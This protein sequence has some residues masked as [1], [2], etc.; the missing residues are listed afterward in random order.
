MT[1]WMPKRTLCSRLSWRVSR[2]GLDAKRDRISAPVLT[3]PHYLGWGV[4]ATGWHGSPA[5]GQ[6]TLPLP[7]RVPACAEGAHTFPTPPP[8]QDGAALTPLPVWQ[9]HGG[10]EAPPQH[11]CLGLRRARPAHRESWPPRDGVSRNSAA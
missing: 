7:C 11:A 1:T 9:V 8:P 5:P 2:A 3:L 10:T 6:P 4:P